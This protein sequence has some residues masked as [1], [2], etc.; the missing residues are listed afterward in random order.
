MKSFRNQGGA[1]FINI[2]TLAVVIGLI[3]TGVDFG[4]RYKARKRLVKAVDEAA[5]AG[6]ALL[7]DEPMAKEIA[8]EKAALYGIDNI[9]I[10]IPVDGD[11]NKI[12]VNAQETV[13]LIF[14]PAIGLNPGDKIEARTVAERGEDIPRFVEREHS[15]R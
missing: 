2:L 12:E 5:I 3:I 7:P 13:S 4:L 15:Y 14:L 9:T 8:R 11:Y 10:A 6:A 1:S